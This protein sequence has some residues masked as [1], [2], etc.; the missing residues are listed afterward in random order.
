MGSGRIAPPRPPERGSFPLDHDGECTVPMRL[1]LDCMK[2]SQN[3]NSRCREESKKYLECRMDRSAYAPC[4][5][6]I[7]GLMLRDSLRNLGYD[8]EN[9]REEMKKG[10]QNKKIEH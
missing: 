7:R 3:D 4:K 2:S 9:V 10:K 8:H 6:N 1:Y 5:A